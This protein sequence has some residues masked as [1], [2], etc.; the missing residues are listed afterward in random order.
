MYVFR[1]NGSTSSRSCA[2]RAFPHSLITCLC[3]PLRPAGNT[4][5]SLGLWRYVHIRSRRRT[6]SFLKKKKRCTIFT[7]KPYKNSFDFECIH[8]A[9]QFWTTSHYS[10]LLC[11]VQVTD[12]VFET[13]LRIPV[14][15]DLSMTERQFVVDSVQSVAAAL[16]AEETPLV[17]TP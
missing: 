15:P 8:S 14:W 1:P 6:I 2:R 7:C 4:A 17:R 12:R 16:R 10:F 13:L 11:T 9:W 5:D 3:I